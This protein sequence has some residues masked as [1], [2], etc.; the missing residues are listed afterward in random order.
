MNENL[1]KIT[2]SLKEIKMTDAEK[3]SGYL[4][5]NNF[6][7]SHPIQNKISQKI[8]SPYTHHFSFINFAKF[9]VIAILIVATGTEGL[10]YASANALPGDLLYPIKIN[11]K[12]G[13]R[14]AMITDTREKTLWQAK[15][16][17][18]RIKEIQDLK[19]T[20]K[21]SE[22]NANIALNT[23]VEHASDL[24]ASLSYAS[25]V[26]DEETLS[27]TTD[28]IKNA[29]DQLSTNKEDS[30]MK[31]SALNNLE[32]T[33]SSS[34]EKDTEE[35]DLN[36]LIE[37]EKSTIEHISKHHKNDS[38]IKDVE[39]KNDDQNKEEIDVDSKD[40]SIDKS[41][42]IESK[43]DEHQIESESKTDESKIFSSDH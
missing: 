18:T 28:K 35:D 34:L 7:N 39:N 13:L 10:S 8:K 2:E 24:N 12:E 37:T 36:S 31:A 3:S 9:A 42:D 25:D 15:R 22:E 20:G 14:G 23:F 29:L 33:D 30:P 17:E 32:K 4:K 27:L 19:S 16:L 1:K 43:I 40:S 38:E 26:G 11:I 41:T 6:I 5:L 21:F